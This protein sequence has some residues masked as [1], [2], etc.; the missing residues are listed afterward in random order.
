MADKQKTPLGPIG[1]TLRHNLRRIREAKRLTY[2]ELSDLLS[3]TGRPIPVLGLRRIERGE[4]RVDADDLAALCV[5]LNVGPAGLLLPPTSSDER[6]NLTEGHS[7]TSRTAW[8]WA[9]GQRTAMDYEPG[10]GVNLAEPGADPAISAEAVERE[11]EF[12]R[13]QAE[14]LAL[15]QPPERR[16]A[17]GHQA[18]RLGRNLADV[19]EDIV[20]PEP[21]VDRSVL[22]A[23]GRM[24]QRR[25]AQLGFELE[26]IIEKLPP[27]HPGVPVR[28]AEDA[29]GAKAGDQS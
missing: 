28:A 6:V 29:S 27:V 8:Q 10:E 4:R 25:H 2:V 26:E 15:T 19:I 18:V 13:K 17:G 14:Y 23:R 21:D 3:K 12:E 1:E 11:Q 5:V 7:V 22:A 16:R 9:E 24:A 20:A